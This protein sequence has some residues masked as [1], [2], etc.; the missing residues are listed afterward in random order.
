MKINGDIL[1][2]AA[3]LN[4]LALGFELVVQQL[5]YFNIHRLLNGAEFVQSA[6]NNYGTHTILIT[7]GLQAYRRPF[8]ILGK[9]FFCRFKERCFG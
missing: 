8:I 7:N 5:V 9:N 3:L 1:S 6:K 4:E 2:F